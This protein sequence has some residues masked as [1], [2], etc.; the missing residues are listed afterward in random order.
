M[1][2]IKLLPAYILSASDVEF[3]N[4]L[5]DNLPESKLTEKQRD[6]VKEIYYKHITKNIDNQAWGRAMY[7]EEQKEKWPSGPRV[8]EHEAK[9]MILE[10]LVFINTRKTLSHFE[11]ASWFHSALTMRPMYAK[12]L[13]NCYKVG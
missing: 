6:R 5:P 11:A 7:E 13:Y 4:S 8:K 12:L 1:K 10:N 3:L 9:R 2:K